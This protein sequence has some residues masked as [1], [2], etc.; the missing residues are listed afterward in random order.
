M[1]KYEY[2]LC[3]VKRGDEILLIN[4]NKHPWF[5]R[6][7][8]VGG[9]IEIDESPRESIIREVFEE[10]D[11]ALQDVCDCG[12]VTWDV[13]GKNRGGMHIYTAQVDDNFVYVTPISKEEG[14]VDWKHIDWILDKRNTGIVENIPKFLPHMLNENVRYHHHCV[15]KDDVMIDITAELIEQ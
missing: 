14:I 12:I 3:F 9:K 2:T 15:F 7:N 4:R 11:I 5:G 10:T 6:W 8:G 1:I 13:D